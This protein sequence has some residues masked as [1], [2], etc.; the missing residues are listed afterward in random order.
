MPLEMWAGLECTLNRVHDRFVDQSVKNGHYERL[1]DLKLFTELG[2][3]KLRYP[4]LWEKVAPDDLE[5]FDWT[6]LDER[7]GEIKRL[8]ITPIAGFLHHGSGPRYTSLIDADFPEKLARYAR[9]F[10]ERYPWIEEYTPVN[11]IN[12]TA[13]FSC[14]YGHWFPHEKSDAAYLRALYNQVKGTIL[15]MKAIR[16]INPKARL[17]QTDDLG[18]A[19]STEPLKYQVNFENERRWLGWDFLCGKVNEEHPIYWYVNKY[20]DLSHEEIQWVI[21]NKC[22]PDMIGVN[23]YHLSNRYLDHRMEL[24]PEW[25]HGGNGIDQYADVGAV[26]TGQAKLPSPSSILIEAWNRY[27]IPLAVTEV[28][29]M[30]NRDSQMRWLFEIWKESKRAREHG[31]NVVAVT[32]WSLLGTYDWHK[33]CTQC[34]GFYEPGVF[35]LRSPDKKPR[36]TGLSRLIKELSSKGDSDHPIL[37]SPGWWKTPRRILW[38]PKDGAYSSVRLRS[39]RPPILITGA[40]GTLG[41]AFA[42]ICGARNIPYRIL[43]RSDMDISNIS[44]VRQVIG[45]IKPWAVINTAGYVR[46]DEAENDPERCYRENVDGPF[47][48]AAV[49]AERGMPIVHFSSDLV[50]DGTSPDAYLESHRKS[51]LSVYGKS[52]AESEEKV[53]IVNPRALIVRTSSFF[54]PWDEYNFVIRTLRH[55]VKKNE[56]IAASDTRM[57]PT[58]VPDLANAT[59]DLLLDGERGIVHLTNQ[60]QVTWQEFA[61]KAV[62]IARV[63]MAIEPSLIIG[64]STAELNLSAQRPKNS[65]LGSERYT[66]LPPLEDALERYIDQL[67]VNIDQQEM[68]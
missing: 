57:S 40:T 1:E 47:N 13:R 58:Y 55:L 6:F 10:A 16:E 18:R 29:T 27:E 14:L 12:T 19:Q 33:L 43:K 21:D 37:K 45:E 52:K 49:C 54:G 23:H 9:A 39:H 42:R 15:A 61:H 65:V 51:P 38:A 22:P 66:M 4:C 20:S 44:Q 67:E 36:H 26:D 28:H 63:K 32:A 50:F 31:A 24:Y 46:V 35:D 8:G 48:L 41:Q 53:L 17:I 3:K 62:D 60:A 59:L 34:E 7:L 68:T 30:G 11:E 56:V 64:K 2:V 5:H 25:S